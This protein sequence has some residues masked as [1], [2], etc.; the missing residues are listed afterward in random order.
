MGDPDAGIAKGELKMVLNGERLKGTFVLVRLKPR[1][2]ERSK[3][4]N[5]LLIKERD[6]YAGP[7]K[8]P[9][10]GYKLTDGSRVFLGFADGKLDSVKHEKDGKTEELLK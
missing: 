6:D 2:G 10:L 7:D 1:K 4:E 9:T 8:A 3:H 5:W